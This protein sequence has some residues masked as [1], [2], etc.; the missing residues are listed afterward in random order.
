MA[1]DVALWRL[2]KT[3]CSIPIAFD[4]LVIH[5]HASA[6]MGSVVASWTTAK[7]A[8]S[9]DKP[10]TVVMEQKWL[11]P[12]ILGVLKNENDKNLRRR[13]MRLIRCVASCEWGRS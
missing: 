12:H 7:P 5:G 11:L 3:I 10:P 8:S 4:S 6:V 13:Y 9:S 2:L 1:S